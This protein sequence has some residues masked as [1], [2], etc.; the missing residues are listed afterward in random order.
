MPWSYMVH[1]INTLTSCVISHLTRLGFLIRRC[2]FLRDDI[3]CVTAPVH[4]KVPDVLI[5]GLPLIM[6]LGLYG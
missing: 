3:F 2:N 1:Y 5:V 6:H 4:E